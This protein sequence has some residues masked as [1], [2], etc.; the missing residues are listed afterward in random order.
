[1][2]KNSII[3]INDVNSC[4]MGRDEIENWLNELDKKNYTIAGAYFDYPDRY[5][6]QKFSNLI[7]IKEFP[8]TPL[9]FDTLSI[10]GMDN[11]IEHVSECRSAFVIIKK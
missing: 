11:F 1:M 9:L 5:S 2:K 8:I 7:N 10:D 6:K 4:N 3:I